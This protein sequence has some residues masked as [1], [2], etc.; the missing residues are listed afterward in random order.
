MRLWKSLDLVLYYQ[1]QCPESD[2]VR[3]FVQEHGLRFQIQYQNVLADDSAREALSA[4]MGDADVP[5]LMIDG[6]PLCHGDE[7]VSWLDQHLVQRARAKR[8]RPR[9][10]R[11]ARARLPARRPLDRFFRDWAD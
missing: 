9:A 3:A 11:S 7:I 2:R 10:P 1:P 8:P 4:T 5:C 6:R